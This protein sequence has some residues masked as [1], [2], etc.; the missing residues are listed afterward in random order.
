MADEEREEP[1]PASSG[2]PGDRDP[3]YV[4]LI[5]QRMREDD[6]PSA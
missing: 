4:D 1:D 6:K 2:E 5:D 3:N